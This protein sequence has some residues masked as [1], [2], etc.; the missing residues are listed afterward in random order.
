MDWA[1]AA[2]LAS[3]FGAVIAMVL[4]WRKAPHETRGIDA[5]AAKTF[6]EAAA[7]S[8]ERSS[9]LEVKIAAMEVRLEAVECE[10]E[11]LEE[12]LKQLEN[13]KKAA[14]ERIQQLEAQVQSLEEQVSALG[15]EPVTK[16]GKPK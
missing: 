14:D 6:E 1:Q 2:S 7:L 12:K 9:R 5:T 8:V 13:E 15:A 11:V 3:I 4:A 10:N 16:K